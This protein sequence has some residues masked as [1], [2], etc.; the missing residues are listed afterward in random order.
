MKRCARYFAYVITV[1]VLMA[2]LVLGSNFI[3]GTIT[4]FFIG[5]EYFAKDYQY[6]FQALTSLGVLS[7][8]LVWWR[9]KKEDRERLNKNLAS[10]SIVDVTPDGVVTIKNTAGLDGTS[11]LVSVYRPFDFEHMFS[12]EN[13]MKYVANGPDGYRE[14]LEA[15][16]NPNYPVWATDAT[17]DINLSIGEIARFHLKDIQQDLIPGEHQKWI[18]F[19]PLKIIITEPIS[20]ITVTKYMLFRFSSSVLRQDHDTFLKNNLHPYDTWALLYS[21]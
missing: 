2:L 14:K 3:R 18:H 8:L 6:T 20:K 10:V 12:N 7:I 11:L 9:Q 15:L 21:R 16:H 13:Y 17:L 4:H 1:F 19:A 5:L